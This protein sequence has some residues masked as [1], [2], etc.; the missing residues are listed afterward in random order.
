MI[1]IYE[2]REHDMKISGEENHMVEL[3]E[4]VR[5]AQYMG[6]DI[7]TTLTDLV[8]KIEYAFDIDG[9]RSLDDEE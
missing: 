5:F 6:M 3:T 4:I 2:F 9:I 7:S 1:K 8:Y